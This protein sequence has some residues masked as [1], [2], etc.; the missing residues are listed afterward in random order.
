M[1]PPHVKSGNFDV[2]LSTYNFSMDAGM[3]VVA[4]KVMAG[5]DRRT[6]AKTK[7]ILK[8]DGAM[9]AALKWTL[10]NPYVH[11]TIPSITDMEQLDE[12][13]RAMSAPFSQAD[14]K[15]LTARLGEIG[16]EYCRMCGACSGQCRY[17]SGP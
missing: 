14:G 16:P 1:I 3:G 12:N 13:L 9:L 11:T 6:D 4:M 17:G 2:V 10:R 8:R 15:V 5:G 7:E